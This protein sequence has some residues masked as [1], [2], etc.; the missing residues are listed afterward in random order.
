MADA[1]CTF[2][3]IVAR[4]EP[5]QIRYENDE[6]LVFDNQLDWVPVMLL[7]I[8]KTHLSQDE[9]WTSGDLIARMGALAVDL[10][11]QYCPDGFRVLSNFGHD[12]LQTQSHGHL[13]IIGGA[14]LGIYVRRPVL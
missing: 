13:H 5:A 3:R 2:C 10:G 12:A 6:V 14:E 7:L 1:Y 9:L 8:P 4:Q 11:N